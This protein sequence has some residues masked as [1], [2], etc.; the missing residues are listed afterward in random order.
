MHLETAAL[1]PD[2]FGDAQGAVD[3]LS[4]DYKLPETLEGITDFRSAHRR[5]VEL[6][7]ARGCTVDVKIVLTKSTR[8]ES[9]QRALTDLLPWREEILLVLQPVTAFG[10]E[11]P[12]SPGWI[13]ECLASAREAGFEPRVLPQVHKVMGVR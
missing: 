5:C 10:G 8:T 3:H 11:E 1:D 6:A 2:A 13:G 9:F 12:P 4:A 7:V